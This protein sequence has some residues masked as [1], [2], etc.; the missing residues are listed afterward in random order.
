MKNLNNNSEDRFVVSSEE[1]KWGINGNQ[2]SNDEINNII[3][4]KRKKLQEKSLD[5]YMIIG[6]VVGI[7]GSFDK[8]MIIGYKVTDSNGENKDYM[9]CKYPNGATET[10]VTFNHE[11]IK[12]VYFV[13]F[14]TE[15]GNEYKSNLNSETKKGMML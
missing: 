5:K 9:A 6:S 8:L 14:T 12:K 11:N 15:Y 7:E 1:I 2:K 4:E 3:K 13:G 10:I